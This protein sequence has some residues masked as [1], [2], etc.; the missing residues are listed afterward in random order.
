MIFHILS[1]ETDFLRYQKFVLKNKNF[2]IEQ[3]FY[4]KLSLF[5]YLKKEMTPR[6]LCDPTKA[7]YMEGPI[8]NLSFERQ[9]R[10]V[11]MT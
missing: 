6:D 4:S 11:G 9:L 5:V 3:I 2:S 8:I 7:W 10:R 1:D